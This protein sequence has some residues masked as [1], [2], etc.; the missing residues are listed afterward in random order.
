[1]IVR[2][3]ESHVAQIAKMEKLCFSDP[4]SER[5]IASE[6]ENSLSLWLVYEQEERVLGY[7]GS[8]S[9]PPESD[10]MNLAVLPEAR[11]Q[12]IAQALVCELI[13]LLHSE[14]SESL[15]LE[16][17]VSNLPA[18]SLYTKLG[19]EMV[20]RRPGYYVNPKEDALIMRK[21]L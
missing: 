8:Q 20:G 7:I 6:L 1:M 15:T 19:F 16:V 14:G 4:W 2:M 9:V 10:M 21:E 11:K 17:R 13:R 3:N 18:I 5:S 12:G